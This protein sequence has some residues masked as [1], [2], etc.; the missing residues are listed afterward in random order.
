MAEFGPDLAGK[1]TLPIRFVGDGSD[2][3]LGEAAHG[4]AQQRD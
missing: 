3:I 2:L 4:L 1:M